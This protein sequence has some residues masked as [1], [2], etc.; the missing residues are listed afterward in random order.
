MLVG[1]IATLI[2]QKGLPD[3]LHVARRVRDQRDDVH[4][5][6]VGEGVMRGELERLRT[7]LRLEDAVTLTGWLTNAASLALP[8]FDIYLQP[9]LWEAM[10]I[11]ILEAM[12]AA[13][14]VVST[15]VG[16][17]PYL[18]EHGVSGFLFE[19]HDVA[20]MAAAILS[21]SRE[22][23]TRRAVGTAAART[24]SERFTVS[25]MARAYEQV[26]VDLLPRQSSKVTH[27]A[28]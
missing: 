14:P 8:T 4:F 21:L 12:A 2:P 9:S 27:A 24:V 10:S 1:T 19:P 15:G 5:V 23:E 17:A 16:E 13:K 11:S 20:G 6:I 26:Y 28:R 25:H 18:I 22:V 7:E 3:L